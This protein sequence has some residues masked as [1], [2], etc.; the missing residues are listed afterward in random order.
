VVN[1]PKAVVEWIKGN[2]V[3][4]LRLV[5]WYGRMVAKSDYLMGIRRTDWG[6]EV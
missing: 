3:D 1:F 2:E 6:N 5:S 4:T